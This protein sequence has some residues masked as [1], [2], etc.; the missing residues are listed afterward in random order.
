MKT[1][2]ATMKPALLLLCAFLLVLGLTAVADDDEKH[3][4][5]LRHVGA[6]VEW[7]IPTRLTDGY[8][9]GPHSIER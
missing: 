8:S 4:G 5:L 2:H 3:D 6:R 7:T 1:K 9:F